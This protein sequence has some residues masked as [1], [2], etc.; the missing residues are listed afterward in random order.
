MFLAFRAAG[1][2]DWLSNLSI[3][4][5][6]KGNIHKLQFHHIFAKALLKNKVSDREADDISNL[7]FIAGK[8]NR[9]ISDKTPKEYITPL[10]EKNK[11][12]PFTTQCIPIDP[13]LLE[14]SRYQDFLAE[15]RR[16][17]AVRL[18][19]FLGVNS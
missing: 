3:S 8:T 6:H 4:L 19:E 7:A 14:L 11:E 13:Q 1:A 2:T 16:R 12:R 5:G 9:G 17:V 18:N 15:R 10:L